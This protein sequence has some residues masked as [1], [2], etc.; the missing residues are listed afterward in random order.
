MKKI[1]LLSLLLALIVGTCSAP[2][3]KPTTEKES[4]NKLYEDFALKIFAR[5]SENLSTNG[6]SAVKTF[7]GKKIVLT[8]QSKKR[9]AA[10]AII[11]KK[12]SKPGLKTITA[13]DLERAINNQLKQ[14]NRAD[15]D[16][17]KETTSKKTG[18]KKKDRKTEKQESIPAITAPPED[19]YKT[20]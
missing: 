7:F 16:L 3:Q 6:F 17:Q 9:L 5:T 11:S 4:I 20:F 14:M 1:N 19:P 10:L 12:Q 13:I 8:K 15:K 2:K 18:K